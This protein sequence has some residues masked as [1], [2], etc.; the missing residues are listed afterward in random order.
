[1][2][3][4]KILHWT[5]KL[6]ILPNGSITNVTNFSIYNSTAVIDYSITYE[7]NIY[8]VESLIEQ[9]LQTL[10]NKYEEL[11][12]TP[13]LLGIE[14][15]SGSDLVFRITAETTPSKQSY[16]ERQIRRELKI[17]LDARLLELEG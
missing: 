16:M 14:R 3:T 12:S 8:K 6:F 10:P 4:T 7:D 13:K 15:V 2:R 1:M 5:G 17:E 9:I 11:I